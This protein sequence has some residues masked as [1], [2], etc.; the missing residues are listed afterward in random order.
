MN[1][2]AGSLAVFATVVSLSARADD[3][4][5]ILQHGIW[6]TRDVTDS[7]VESQQF[8]N[9]V[10]S[11]RSEHISHDGSWAFSFLTDNNRYEMSKQ[12]CSRQGSSIYLSKDFRLHY[13]DAAKAIVD[14]WSACKKSQDESDQ[15]GASVEYTDDPNKFAIYLLI[16]RGKSND[17]ADVRIPSGPDDA[18]VQCDLTS[19]DFSYNR[20]VICS[21][22]SRDQA[23]TALLSVQ[24][25]S[26]S[27]AL[28]IIPKV[29]DSTEVQ[30]PAPTHAQ[31]C[32]CKGQGGLADVTLWQPKGTSC[33]GLWDPPAI[34]D[35]QQENTRI[36]SCVGH[37]GLE[38]IHLWGPEGRNACGDRWPDRPYASDAQTRT[39]RI[40][41]CTGHGGL[42]GISLWGP[43]GDA[44]GGLWPDRT[45]SAD[46]QD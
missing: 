40:C 17:H 38:G 8:A 32:S 19:T 18:N 35:C 1:V 11:N 14:A 27:N 31:L 15:S 16:G 43:E 24:F 41:R 7:G 2:I 36:A 4:S 44:C 45:Y 37:G 20:Y 28:V 46:C 3:C 33:G 13:K 10:C 9:W 39:R 30:I 42:E 23:K 21:R 34:I 29:P 5:A 26:G 22:S 25:K 6:Q 12:D